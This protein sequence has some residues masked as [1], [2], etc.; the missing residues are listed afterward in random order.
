M[1][2]ALLGDRHG[3]PEPQLPETNVDLI[4]QVGDFG[5]Y[6]KNISTNNLVDYNGI[7]QVFIRGNHEDHSFLAHRTEPFMYGPW[8]FMPDG[9][10]DE[11]EIL[12][13]GGAWSI[14]RGYRQAIAHYPGFFDYWSHLEEMSEEKMEEIFQM[15][16]GESFR[17][18]ITHEAPE[19][20]FGHLVASRVFERNRTAE[21]FSRLINHI[22]TPLWAF[23]HH[24]K[25]LHVRLGSTDFHCINIDEWKCISIA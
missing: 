4:V 16:R 20:L 5:V 22:R 19:F 3:Q 21:F 11:N 8:E 9:Y 10:V 12:Y 13:M 17:A 15:V 24:H 25:S 6:P 23:G 1:K 18:V 7:K 14:D 2:I